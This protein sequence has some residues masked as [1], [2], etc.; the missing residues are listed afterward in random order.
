M[1]LLVLSMCESQGRRKPFDWY[2]MRVPTVSF[3]DPTGEDSD[4]REEE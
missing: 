1:S 3:A 4:A 2:C